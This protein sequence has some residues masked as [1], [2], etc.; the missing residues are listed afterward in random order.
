MEH[1]Q[2]GLADV[3]RLRRLCEFAAA[4]KALAEAAV[5]GADPFDVEIAAGRLD[6]DQDDFGGALARFD[7]AVALNPDREEA[8]A[9]RVATLSRLSRFAEA[10]A[11]AANGLERFPNSA[12]IGVALARLSNDRCQ[13]IEALAEFDRVLAGHPVDEN[14]LEWRI[15]ALRELHRYADAEAASQVA[16]AT[17][18]D[19]PG[20]IDSLASVYRDQGRYGEALACYERILRLAPDN[21]LALQGRISVLRRASRYEEAEKAAAEA[22]SR[23]PLAAGV[24]VS[25][26][27]L[28]EARG[29]YAS[30][31]DRAEQALRVQ[32][33]C[34]NALEQ[35]IG[36]L[37]ELHQYAA[38]KAAAEEARASHPRSPDIIESLAWTYEAQ[39]RYA[40]ALE[41]FGQALEID[42]LHAGALDGRATAL[43][44]LGLYADAETAI[45]EAAAR[46]PHAIRLHVEWG[47]LLDTQG[48]CTDALERFEHALAIDPFHSMAMTWRITE[49]RILERFAEA[50]EVARAALER[51][52]A[53]SIWVAHGTVQADQDRGEEALAAFEHALDLDPA[54]SWAH[55]WLVTVL[56]R[57]QRYAEAE[58]AARRAISRLPGDASLHRELGWV[59]ADQDLDEFALAEFRRASEVDP[60]DSSGP[61]IVA[62]AL[63]WLNRYEE[64]ERVIQ[65]ALQKWPADPDLMTELGWIFMNQYR[66]SEALDQFT[67][68]QENDPN[69][70]RT[71]PRISALRQAGRFGE[72]LTLARDATTRRPDLPGLCAALA[73]VYTDEGNYAE[74]EGALREAMQRLPSSSDLT[75]SLVKLYRW[76]GRCEEALSECDRMLRDQ[77]QLVTALGQ[78]AELLEDLN[79]Y[80][81]ASKPS[82]PHKRS[83]L[84][85]RNSSSGSAGCTTNWGATTRQSV[86]STRPLMRAT[87][88]GRATA[89]R[90]R[91]A[92]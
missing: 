91:C 57:L 66:Y 87:G 41:I 38:A 4:A 17:L 34:H 30:A 43:R 22:A 33:R 19:C 24:Y 73:D 78:R 13:P 77:P 42:D 84:R 92:G 90:L 86:N 56:R 29:H 27:Y 49:L 69:D 54:Y 58:T 5:A 39:G 9:W 45:A 28:D 40:E 51:L 50:E 47:I 32:P 85:I 89:E 88:G 7:S 74:A 64:A 21:L 61:A 15:E 80:A 46:I 36:V 12:P 67:S 35:R 52:P 75:E 71:I 63:R 59:Y 48:R 3:N 23:L 8:T 70:L 16:L 76:L 72:A 55:Q 11:V 10:R 62:R 79:R 31:L 37:R 68:A 81:E 2:G 60:G 53:P 44:R 83:I 6:L 26:S 82:A 18:P 65:G 1:E 20:I 25:W 14:A